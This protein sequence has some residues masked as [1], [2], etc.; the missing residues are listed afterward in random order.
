MKVALFALLISLCSVR[1][2]DVE[3]VFNE[4]TAK[5]SDTHKARIEAIRS[6]WDWL[7]LDNGL[8]GPGAVVHIV[9]KPGHLGTG[10]P[11]AFCQ[12]S[13]YSM[14]S[15]GKLVLNGEYPVT[16]HLNI[17]QSLSRWSDALMGAVVFHEMG[18]C[19]GMDE[20]SFLLNK[21]E[22]GTLLL[23]NNQYTGAAALAVYRAEFDPGA[24]FI[25]MNGP[26]FAESMFPDEV[27]TP[28]LSISRISE[29]YVSATLLAVIQENGW[30]VRP[31]FTGGLLRNLT[32]FR[33]LRDEDVFVK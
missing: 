27:A 32:P 18:H 33:R 31:G 19:F 14:N 25:P 29:V 10:G 11:L 3:V 21:C 16:I 5:L 28:A 30:A 4:S 26:H 8:P 13:C 17:D 2:G 7:L 6:L 22:G 12:T 23:P 20:A 9:V 1:A 15:R 24:A